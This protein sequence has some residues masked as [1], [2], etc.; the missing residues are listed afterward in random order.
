MKIK[1]WEL[2]VGE[3]ILYT[4]KSIE[5]IKLT[6]LEYKAFKYYKDCELHT[7]SEGIRNLYRERRD[8]KKNRNNL[9]EIIH[10]TNLKIKPIGRIE[11]RAG[12]GHKFIAEIGEK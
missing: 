11:N 5:T 1:D 8:T 6:P 12:F 4:G 9:K 10:R 3:I 2:E 7:W